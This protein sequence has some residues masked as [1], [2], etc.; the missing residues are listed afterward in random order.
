MKQEFTF[1]E[2]YKIQIEHISE[3]AI[4]L[5]PESYSRLLGKVIERNKQGY[6][7]PYNVARGGDL[8]QFVADI[9]REMIKEKASA[10]R[11]RFYDNVHD[12]EN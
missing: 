6:K 11:R 9:T 12:N 4:V 2:A 5:N 8:S 3:W 10:E 1:E 7:S